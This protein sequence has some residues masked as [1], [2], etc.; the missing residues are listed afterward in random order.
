[1]RM[2]SV[3]CYARR[4]QVTRVRNKAF[5][6]TYCMCVTVARL[7]LTRAPYLVHMWALTHYVIVTPSRIPVCFVYCTAPLTQLTL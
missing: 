5:G 1:M 2:S 3:Q 6:D 7:T 4:D